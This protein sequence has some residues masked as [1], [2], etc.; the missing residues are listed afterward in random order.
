MLTRYR[1]G[2]PPSPSQA[3]CCRVRRGSWDIVVSGRAFW[4]AGIKCVRSI[5]EVLACFW[6]RA[7]LVLGQVETDRA[8]SWKGLWILSDAKSVFSYSD[9]KDEIFLTQC[10]GLNVWIPSTPRPLAPPPSTT[11]SVC[12][13]PTAQG[14]SI[15]RRGSWGVIHE[16]K[17]PWME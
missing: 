4:A 13:K 10:C 16:M 5:R 15:W 7:G 14:N 8:R 1:A 17:P 12:W 11:K 3:K 9:W 6:F 2:I